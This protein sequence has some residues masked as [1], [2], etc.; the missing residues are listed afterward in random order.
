MNSNIENDVAHISD[1]LR[2]MMKSADVTPEMAAKCIDKPVT[3]F[4]N[5]LSLDR[6]S[7]KELIILAELCDYHLAFVP[8]NVNQPTEFLLAD[9]Y[10]SEDLSVLKEYRKQ[11]LQKHLDVLNTYMDGMTIEEKTDFINQHLGNMIKG[12]EKIEPK[13]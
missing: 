11:R 4:R 6:F 10:I 5:K 12:T 8:D 13:K 3:S 9:K 2:S 7:V 1:F